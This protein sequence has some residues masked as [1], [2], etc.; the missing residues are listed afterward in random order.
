MLEARELSARHIRQVRTSLHCHQERPALCQ[1]HA[2]LACSGPNLQH[3][4]PLSDV[5]EGDEII[6]QSLGVRRACP[7]IRVRY[8]V[9]RVPS[10]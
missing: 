4:G 7:V 6:D 8:G 3:P 5:R 2:E 10:E 1:R 9:E